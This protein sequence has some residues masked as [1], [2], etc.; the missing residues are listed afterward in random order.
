MHFKTLAVV[1]NLGDIKENETHN[2]SIKLAIDH[3][4]QKIKNKKSS[5]VDK[6]SLEDLSTK[7]STF[8]R[9]VVREVED[10]MAK[11]CENDE[12]YFTSFCD[13]TDEL[14]E[15][16]N[17]DTVGCVKLANGKIVWLGSDECPVGYRYGNDKPFM[18]INDKI[19]QSEYGP[20]HTP[21]TNKKS[22]KL[23]YLQS[24]PARKIFK[25]F[26]EY[27]ERYGGYNYDETYECYGYYF[28]P[29][30]IWDWYQVG[31]RWPY[32]FLVKDDMNEYPTFI[33]KD[34]IVTN[35]SKNTSFFIPQAPE[36]YKW[37]IM[38]RKKDICW[39]KM[40]ES[41][42]NE[43]IKNFNKI[44]EVFNS[45]DSGDTFYTKKGDCVYE[46]RQCVYKDGDTLEDYLNKHYVADNYKYFYD[47]CDIVDNDRW[48]P[49]YEYE[50]KPC[51]PNKEKGDNW[52]KFISDYIDALD[53][54]DVLVG[55]DYHS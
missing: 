49:S 35:N 21:K 44:Q 46:F 20:N 53:D 17:N 18:L 3:I 29:N 25:T 5:I 27:A 41:Y 40:K 8:S 33:S 55:I 31:G 36:G 48:Y 37:T 23:K 45:G 54:T 34:D 12:Q 11:Y 4:E 50:N 6:I 26:N 47:V 9:S 39:D 13:M 30:A 51:E 43:L 52:V 14:K 42:K 22:K 32:C 7:I 19:Y 2:K 1:K 28:N 38:A 10:I 15:S 24:Y 16:Y